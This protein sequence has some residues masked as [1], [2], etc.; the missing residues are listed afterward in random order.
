MPYEVH[1]SD[2]TKLHNPNDVRYSGDVWRPGPMIAYGGGVLT[3]FYQVG[4]CE[5]HWSNGTNLLSGDVRFSS[6]SVPVM[7]MISY[8]NKRGVTGVLTAFKRGDRDHVIHWSPDGHNLGGGNATDYYGGSSEVT[9]MV[10]YTNRSG[11]TGVLTAFDRGPSDHVVHWS[12][13][14]TH[15]GGGNAVEYYGGSSRVNVMIP[16]DG[17]VLTSFTRRADDNV[18]HRSQDGKALGGG[19][20][21]EYYGGTAFAAPMIPFKT[22]VLTSFSGAAVHFSPNG[23]N[24][25]SGD[26]RHPGPVQ[27]MLEYNGGVLTAF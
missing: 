23:R 22:G 17:E 10:V 25:V 8:T 6:P 12:E 3:A 7:A 20:A 13:D 14:G 9:A 26:I 24:L 19:S 21:V 16:Y 1:W 18:V 5:V 27:A 4:G 15:L 11:I 2:G